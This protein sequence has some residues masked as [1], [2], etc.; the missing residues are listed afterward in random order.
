[1]HPSVAAL[2]LILATLALTSSTKHP[3]RSMAA[4]LQA[5]LQQN[6]DAQHAKWNCSIAVALRSPSHSTEVLGATAG[7]SNS[8][9][10]LHAADPRPAQV[11]DP[12]VWGSTTKMYTGPA[13]LQLVENGVVSLH[14]R[15]SK[16]IDPLLA[17]V[18]GTKL[19][20]KFGAKIDDVQVHHLLHMTSGIGD[21]DRGN[22]SKDQF[23]SPGHDFSPIEILTK[24]VPSKFDFEPGTKQNYC[25]TNYIL[26]GLVLARHLSEDSA[27]WRKYDQLS[28]IPSA[29]RGLYKHSVFADQG[30]CSAFTPQ[31]AFMAPSY[32]DRTQ[33][34][35]KDVWNVSCVGGWTGGNFVGSVKDVARYTYDLYGKDPTA[36]IVS[37][38]SLDHM[39]NFTA[40]SSHHH[41]FKFYGMGT[42]SLDW[43]AS[44][45]GL[46]VTGYGHV[47]DT[48]G[49]Q[50]QTTYFPGL[51][52]VLTVATNIET[53]SQ[54]Q[55]AETTCLLY[56][57]IAATL[58]GKPLPQCSFKVPHQ[59]IGECACK[60]D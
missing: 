16:H 1:M 19:Q 51:D 47:G 52:L 17:K 44:T 20:D 28:V 50:S 43:T 18:T 55:P 9:L 31:H 32:Y 6:V 2:F 35:D 21:Y 3:S 57:A 23:A 27:S 11:D 25:S 34:G 30:A 60:D 10:S 4:G 54:A 59:F 49:Y 22:Y 24:Y 53:A 13:V 33:K 29:S 8:G 38:R 15:I 56:H 7:Y 26:L 5:V 37:P 39:L 12:Y 45:E 58:A 14:D 48:Y 42:F 40:P 36:P 46:N 41:S